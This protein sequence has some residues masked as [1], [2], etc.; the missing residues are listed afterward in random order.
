M[1]VGS[2][3][4]VPPRRASHASK[5]QCIQVIRRRRNQTVECARARVDLVA[6]LPIRE[7]DHLIQ[8]VCLIH[9]SDQ[10]HV[11]TLHL[12]CK[13]FSS[14]FLRAC[15]SVS[16]HFETAEIT[17]RRFSTFFAATAWL[18]LDTNF[19]SAR[20]RF[21][22]IALG[23]ELDLFFTFKRTPLPT[24]HVLDH[25][26]LSFNGAAARPRCRRRLLQCHLYPSN[27]RS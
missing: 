4:R 26:A 25:K 18:L 13:R 1:A 22:S 10:A 6:I 20:K 17:D 2:G 21:R 11:A 27:A 3:S 7:R 19:V 23:P 12:R 24:H 9:T 8:Q 14:N 16:E 5:R 15:Y